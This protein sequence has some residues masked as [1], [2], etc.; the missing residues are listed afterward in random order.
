MKFCCSPHRS[1]TN[2]HSSFLKLSCSYHKVKHQAP[3]IFLLKQ[4][5]AEVNALSKRRRKNNKVTFFLPAY[6]IRRKCLKS[7]KTRRNH[8]PLETNEKDHL[9]CVI[10]KNIFFFS[11]WTKLFPEQYQ[12]YWV[13]WIFSQI[14]FWSRWGTVQITFCNQTYLK[15]SAMDTLQ[16]Y[17]IC[18]RRFLHKLHYQDRYVNTVFFFF[19]PYYFLIVF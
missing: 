14:S 2:I 15:V 3:V 6:G 10:H 8:L 13:C 4:S 1:S 11:C 9:C 12:A 5:N 17:K 16:L 18:F 7:S 19:F